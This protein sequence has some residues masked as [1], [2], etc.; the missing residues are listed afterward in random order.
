MGRYTGM[1]LGMYIGM[2]I[3]KSMGM[4]VGKGIG[5]FIDMCIEM[6]GIDMTLRMGMVMCVDVYRHFRR[7][8]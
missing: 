5:V 4:Y 8:V 2:Y 6:H 1:C 7:V 3:G